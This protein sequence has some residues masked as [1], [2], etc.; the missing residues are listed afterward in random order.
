MSTL[1]VVLVLGWSRHHASH[2]FVLIEKDGVIRRLHSEAGEANVL[3]E[4][5]PTP[6]FLFAFASLREIFSVRRTGLRRVRS[7]RC[8]LTRMIVSYSRSFVSIR[9]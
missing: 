7:T 2:R 1:Q 4:K 5:G 3:Y 9:D 6:S 8:E